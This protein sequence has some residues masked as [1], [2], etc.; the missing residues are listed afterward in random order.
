MLDVRFN[1][2]HAGE[3]FQAPGDKVF[4]LKVTGSCSYH[5]PID[6]VEILVNGDVAKSLKPEPVVPSDGAFRY[7]LD[8]DQPIEQSGWIAVRAFAKSGER[9][10]FAHSAPVHVTIPGKPLKPKRKE[11]R[12]FVRRMQEEIARNQSVLD[13]ASLAEYQKA[14]EVYQKLEKNAE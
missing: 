5:Q 3:R 8:Y 4:S 12:Y 14:L 13:Q 7:H 9:I 11:V 10:R 6:R 2:A 1:G